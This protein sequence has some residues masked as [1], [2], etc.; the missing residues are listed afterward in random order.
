MARQHLL[1]SPNRQKQRFPPGG[2]S[3]N[4][5]NN[6]SPRRE[7]QKTAKTTFPSGGKIKKLRKRRFPPEGKS[8]NSENNVSPRRENEKTA[9]TAFPS[10]GKIKKLQKQRFPPEG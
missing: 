4:D 1:K 6:A 7:N 8:K 5:E 2:K 10:G 9:K 3:E